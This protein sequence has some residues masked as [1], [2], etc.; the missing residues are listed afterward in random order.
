MVGAKNFSEQYILAELMADR[1][2]RGRRRRVERKEDLGSAIAYRALA[3]GEIDAY[4]DYSGTLW[5]NVLKRTRQS[6][7]RRRCW[8]S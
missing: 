1:L 4:V 7:P 6:R 5:A 8:T 2:Q 3:S